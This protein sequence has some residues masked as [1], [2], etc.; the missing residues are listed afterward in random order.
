MD[1]GSEVV[2]LSQVEYTKKKRNWGTRQ[3][4]FKRTGSVRKWMNVKVVMEKSISVEGKEI[5]YFTKYGNTG[6]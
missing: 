4:E 3:E 5:F 1:L 2:L 6:K